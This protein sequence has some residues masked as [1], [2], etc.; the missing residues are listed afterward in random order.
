MKVV[1]FG[2]TGMVGRGVLRE[3][4]VDP[5][6]STVVTIVRRSTGASDPKLV[7]LVT[8]QV[9]AVDGFE[10]PLRGLDACFFCLGVSSVGKTEAEYTRTTYDLT[11]SVA[12]SLARWNSGTMT[13]VYVSGAGTDSSERG[14]SMWAR[15][16][17]RTE[18]ALGRLPFRAVYF[19]RPGIIQPRHGIRSNSAGVRI[20]YAILWP[21]LPLLLWAAPGVTTT[22][23]R[24]GRAMIALAP[25]LEP[26]PVIDS[27][28]I[29]RLGRPAPPASHRPATTRPS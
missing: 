26:G 1:V 3:C 18:N 5:R 15:V 14:S 29:N 22:T 8:P 25:G 27:R 6:V 12:T 11:M 10:A 13:F 24:V 7:E 17:G 28:A 16:K 20:V 4:L 2:A 9:G 19:F 23:D 21:F